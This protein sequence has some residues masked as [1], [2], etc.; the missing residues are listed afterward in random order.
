MAT[1]ELLSE[2]CDRVHARPPDTKSVPDLDSY[3]TFLKVLD[4]KIRSVPVSKSA[5]DDTSYT[6]TAVELY[7]LAMLVYLDR[8]SGDL[9]DQ[10]TKTRQQ[11]DKAFMI[12]AQLS[13][14]ERQFPLF[15]LGCEAR[16]DDQRAIILDLISRTEKSISSRS[17]L[18]VKLLLQAVWAQD[19]LADHQLTYWDKL[20]SMMSCC[21]VVPSLV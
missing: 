7:R 12:F 16:T 11:V 19:D 2:V 15:I 18:H 20:S 10:P 5:D 13:S 9:L 1:L 6:T 17:P 4:W 14:C 21:A 3:K 8:I